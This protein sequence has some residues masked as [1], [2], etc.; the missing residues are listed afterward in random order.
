MHII[1]DL[2]LKHQKENK[3]E[4][5]CLYPLTWE[6]LTLSEVINFFPVPANNQFT[7]SMNPTRSVP[8]ENLSEK[9]DYNIQG[10]LLYVLKKRISFNRLKEYIYA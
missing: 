1:S 7:S 2:A 6:V 9:S 3:L 4:K 5:S 10:M 8:K